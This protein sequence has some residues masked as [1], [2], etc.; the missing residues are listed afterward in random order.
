MNYGNMAAP[1]TQLLK[2]DSFQWNEGAT[3]AFEL[4]K[5]AMVT[6]LVL[7]LSDFSIPF[8]IKTDVSGTGVGAMLSQRQCPIA[9][10]SQFLS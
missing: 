7:A 10:F 8:V 9:Y 3:K 4:L 5:Q 6:I 1:L 2:K